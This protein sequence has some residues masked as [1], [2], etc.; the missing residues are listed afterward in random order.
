M[1]RLLLTQNKGF[2]PTQIPQFS[3]AT[4]S[5]ETAPDSIG[6]SL[7]IQVSH[8]GGANQSAIA[9]ADSDSV[10]NAYESPVSSASVL[11]TGETHS[12]SITD[13]PR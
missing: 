1:C 2:I 10:N 13:N 8:N 3:I 4:F 6:I 12:L 9:G 11:V 7:D 5:H